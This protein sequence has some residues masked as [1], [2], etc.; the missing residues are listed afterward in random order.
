M[1]MEGYVGLVVVEHILDCGIILQDIN[2]G[3]F[4][5]ELSIYLDI[6]TLPWMTLERH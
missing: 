6:S 1:S 5:L 2:N 4:M 3:T